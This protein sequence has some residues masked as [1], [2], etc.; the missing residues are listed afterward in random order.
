[1]KG[2]EDLAGLV[3]SRGDIESILRGR[4]TIQA[5]ERI[6]TR[7]HDCF[8]SRGGEERRG[9]LSCDAERNRETRGGRI[10]SFFTPMHIPR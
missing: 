6:Y 5:E 2:R 4:R 9:R 3:E 1:M 7:L 10:E 8:F